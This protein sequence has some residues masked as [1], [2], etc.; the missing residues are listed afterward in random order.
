MVRLGARLRRLP[1]DTLTA[2]SFFS[3]LPVRPAAGSFDLRESA[4][5]WPIAGLLLA[6]APAALFWLLEI[7]EFPSVVSALLALAL[8]AAL[9]GAVHEDGLA[10][11]ADGLGGGRGR[12][13]KLAIMRDSRV[14]SYGVL[15]LVFCIGVKA[16]ALASI[17]PF[18]IHGSVAL[19]GAAVLSRAMALWHWNA[20]MPARTEG[21]AWAAG[22]PDWTALGIGLVAGLLAAVPL[23]IIF[24]L[25]AVIALLAGAAAVA[26]LSSLCRRKIGGHTGDTI[27]AAQ[28]LAEMMLLAGFSIGWTYFIA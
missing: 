3:R 27:G 18:P 15:A 8:M 21:M 12:E 23:L 10:D 1:A 11:T 16:Q 9:T 14:G 25:A 4:A 13:G 22:R 5:A 26:V 6:L 28:Q 24:E 7:A 20:T 2:L 17:G 19:V